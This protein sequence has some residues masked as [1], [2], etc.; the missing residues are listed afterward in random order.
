M[1]AWSEEAPPDADLPF[2]AAAGDAPA[3]LGWRGRWP[4]PAGSVQY[5][6]VQVVFH[7]DDVE[8]D[9]RRR[10]PTHTVFLHVHRDCPPERVRE[11]AALA[12]CAPLGEARIG[13]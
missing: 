2:L 4:G 1:W 9:P 12:G 11:L 13:W 7:H 8:L 5:D 6:G 3:L 10:T